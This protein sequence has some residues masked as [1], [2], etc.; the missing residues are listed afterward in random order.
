M[1]GR[2]FNKP[3]PAHWHLRKSRAMY[4]NRRQDL[5]QTYPPYTFPANEILFEQSTESL[6]NWLQTEQSTGT[7][8]NDENTV[9]VITE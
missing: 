6:Y 7:K 5:S 4:L 2:P 3:K 8:Y 9:L 1:I